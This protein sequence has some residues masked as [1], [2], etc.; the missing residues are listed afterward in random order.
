MGKR[1]KRDESSS[2][3]AWEPG[4]DPEEL[5]LRSETKDLKE[6]DSEA[7]KSEC[8]ESSSKGANK[9]KGKRAKKSEI[10]KEKEKKPK[11]PKAKKEKKD[12]KEKEPKP[13]KAKKPDDLLDPLFDL[14]QAYFYQKETNTDEIKEHVNNYFNSDDVDSLDAL[15]AQLAKYPNL[16]KGEDNIN[17]LLR[18]VDKA[19]I[20]TNDRDDILE[21]YSN[22]TTYIRA[23]YF[24]YKPTVH[25]CYFFPNKDNEIYVANMLRTCKSTLDIAIFTM[26]NNKISA[27][28]EEA[29]NR[30]VKVR[31]IADDECAKMKGGDIYRL[32]L[33]GIPT[34]TDNNKR[35]HMHHKFAVLDN[36]VVLTGSFNWTAQ[37]VKYNQ[38]NILFYENQEIAHKYTAAYDQIWNEF[39]TV[40]T[41]QIAKEYLEEEKKAS[42]E[43]YSKKKAEKTIKK[44][45]KEVTKI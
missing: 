2:G 4:D 28:I 7:S 14:E 8:D 35:F 44:V 13:S 15:K 18:Q 23:E 40:I 25:E 11:D 27:S 21:K 12:K 41:K 5:I 37:A 3:S 17:E 22:V 1:A 16:R 29:F 10:K 38:E 36:S 20:L 45:I 43:Y 34:K 26:T 32:A 9:R 30:G 33:L 24:R 42:D 19:A 39:T 31:V 6:S